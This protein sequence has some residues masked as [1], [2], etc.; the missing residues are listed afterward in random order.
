LPASLNGV[1]REESEKSALSSPSDSKAKMR[2]CS[3]IFIKDRI[4]VSWSG[5][6]RTFLIVLYPESSVNVTDPLPSA[7]TEFPPTPILLQSGRCAFYT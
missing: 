1:D 3:L 6:Y 7:E 2:L 4:G 5:T